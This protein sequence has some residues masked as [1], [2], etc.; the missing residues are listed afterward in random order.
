MKD[1]YQRSI[2]K[3]ISWRFVA[4]L[5]TMIIIFAFT[6]KIMLSLGVGFFEAISKIILY[7]IHERFWNKI[8]WGQL[9]V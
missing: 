5:T 6:G 3:S 9:Q 4:T 8:S 1:N 2:I 7:Y